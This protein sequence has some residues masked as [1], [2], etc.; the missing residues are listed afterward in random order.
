METNYDTLRERSISLGEEAEARMS[1]GDLTAA[2]T[3]YL[4]ALEIDET[5][6]RELDTVRA[7]RDLGITR[8]TLS[9]L[10]RDMGELDIAEEMVSNAIPQFEWV[11]EREDS[12]ENRQDLA[13]S[14]VGLSTVLLFKGL[15]LPA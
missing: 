4:Q 13:M 8:Q 3:L 6:C 14:H 11:L 5:L 12:L 2:E 1:E 9:E 10:Y 7:H 15:Y